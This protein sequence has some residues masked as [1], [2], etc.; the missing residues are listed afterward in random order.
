[1]KYTASKMH[2]LAV[3]ALLWVFHMVVL[4]ITMEEAQSRADPTRINGLDFTRDELDAAGGHLRMER[5]VH[6]Y[7]DIARDG[8]DEQE[9]EQLLHGTG[10]TRSSAEDAEVS[11]EAQRVLPSTTQPI[12]LVRWDAMWDNGKGTPAAAASEHRAGDTLLL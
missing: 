10:S 2:L 7:Y 12:A 1:M 8:A 6:R 5:D 11:E 9:G 4:A 3:D